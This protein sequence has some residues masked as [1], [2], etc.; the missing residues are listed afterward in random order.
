MGSAPLTSTLVAPRIP[1]TVIFVLLVLKGPSIDAKKDVE[2]VA[3]RLY[4]VLGVSPILH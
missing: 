3:P 1:R 4:L 2:R